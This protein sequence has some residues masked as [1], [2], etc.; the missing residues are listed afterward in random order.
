MGTLLFNLIDTK[1]EAQAILN[2]LRTFLKNES[3]LKQMITDTQIQLFLE[4]L[5]QQRIVNYRV[6]HIDGSVDTPY[7][8]TLFLNI[9]KA[10]GILAAGAIDTPAEIALFI[11]ALQKQGVLQASIGNAKEWNVAIDQDNKHRPSSKP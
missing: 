1:G 8:V 7:E 3:H 4:Q 2:V 9:L 11:E 5:K 6:N 10:N